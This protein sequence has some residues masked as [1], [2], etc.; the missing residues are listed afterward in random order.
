MAEVKHKFQRGD[1]LT[2]NNKKGSFMIYEGNNLSETAYK[3]MTLV[4]F[5]DPEKFQMGP[6]GYEEKP[7]LELAS[8][9]KPCPTTIDTE[10]EDY[11]IHLC[12]DTEKA[13]ALKVLKKYGLNWDEDNMELSSLETGEIIRKIFIPDNKYYGQLIK[14]ISEQSKK[15]IRKY[16]RSKIAPSYSSQ[17]YSEEYYED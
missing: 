1:F 13:E 9:D 2:R 15:L 8:K 6:V 5:Y 3:R 17:H 12:S 11:W 4:C 16:C 10:E 7:S 14:P